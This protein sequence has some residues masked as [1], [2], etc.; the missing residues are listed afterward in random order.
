MCNIACLPSYFNDNVSYPRRWANAPNNYRFGKSS[1]NY[2]QSTVGNKKLVI[3]YFA[4][5]HCSLAPLNW[6]LL[7]VPT[8]AQNYIMEIGLHSKSYFNRKYLR[9]E[10]NIFNHF[11]PSY[12]A[13]SFTIALLTKL[14]FHPLCHTH[15]RTIFHH[16]ITVK[17]YVGLLL[18]SLR[19]YQPLPSYLLKADF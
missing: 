7:K 3:K 5:P 19:L 10:K 13:K 17:F 4:M 6:G 14:F 11:L 8:Q 2:K 1:F 9:E 18:E 16:W 15:T 12:F